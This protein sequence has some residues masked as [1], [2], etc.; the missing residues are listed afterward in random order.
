MGCHEPHTE[1]ELK[2]VQGKM[3]RQKKE[4]RQGRSP[5]VVSLRQGQ[6]GAG[7]RRAVDMMPG[8][9]GTPRLNWRRW[10]VRPGV[11]VP[12]RFLWIVATRSRFKERACFSALSA[13]CKYYVRCFWFA[14]AGHGKFSM[15]TLPKRRL[16]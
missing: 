9:K 1:E 8:V 7:G 13:Y 6:R 14:Q 10:D 16:Q 2:R 4:G 15:V 12:I 11:Q 3:R 5:V